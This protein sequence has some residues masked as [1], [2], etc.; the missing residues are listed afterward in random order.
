M[1]ERDSEREKPDHSL[2]LLAVDGDVIPELVHDRH[3]LGGY[4]GVRVDLLQQLVQLPI[5][6][7]WCPNWVNSYIC[8]SIRN[9][10]KNSLSSTQIKN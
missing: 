4:T 2:D 1:S 6:I 5:L 8:L 9:Q 7:L 10:S 3:C